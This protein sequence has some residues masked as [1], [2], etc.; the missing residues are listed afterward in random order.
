MGELFQ[1]ALVF[2][3]A[4]VLLVI[5][6]LFT[7]YRSS[8]PGAVTAVYS[9]TS[10]SNATPSRSFSANHFSAASA[11]ANTASVEAQRRP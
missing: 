9:R 10:Y 5:G 11:V 1:T 4:T 3:F 8:A 6:Q 2:V 7:K